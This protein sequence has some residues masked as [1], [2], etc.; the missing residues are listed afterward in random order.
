M[1]WW[2]NVALVTAAGRLS[3]TVV[4]LV[5]EGLFD[6]SMLA[7]RSMVELVGN[8]GYM[9]QQP[10]FRAPEFAAADLRG[11]ERLIEGMSRIGLDSEALGDVRSEVSKARAEMV[12]L[13]GD[14]EETD[15]I[16]PFGRKARVR[17]ESA[18]MAWHYDVVYAVASDYAHMN[19]RAVME[20]LKEP[21]QKGR[22]ARFRTS[23]ETLD[24]MRV[25]DAVTLLCGSSLVSAQARLP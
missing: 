25:S 2:W 21:G 11:R 19:A 16:L 15:S 1:W 5:K 12:S 10:D 17:F 9:A 24:G 20:Y 7:I 18:G 23:R 13:V 6:E 4:I 14:I 8:Q 22:G 3:R